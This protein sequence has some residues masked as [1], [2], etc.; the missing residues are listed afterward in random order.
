MVSPAWSALT[1]WN[2]A[3]PGRG[4]WRRRSG[5]GIR[6]R[7][8]RLHVAEQCC[9]LAVV[10]LPD[11]CVEPERPGDDGGA[12]DDRGVDRRAVVGAHLEVGPRHVPRAGG[13]SPVWPCPCANVNGQLRSPYCASGCPSAPRSPMLKGLGP[14]PRGHNNETRSRPR[15]DEIRRTIEIRTGY[16]TSWIPRSENPPGV[17]VDWTG[18]GKTGSR[19]TPVAFLPPLHAVI[20][21]PTNPTMWYQ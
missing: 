10:V 7:Q 20:W 11:V 19:Q 13:A 17:G 18:P 3:Q 15:G 2:V 8:R 9:V 5:R 6:C 12:G 4:R 16:W 14:V 21:N 1:T